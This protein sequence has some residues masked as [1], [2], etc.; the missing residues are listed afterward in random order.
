M[1]KAAMDVGMKPRFCMLKRK[2]IVNTTNRDAHV[3]LDKSSQQ[4]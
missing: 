4:T 3:M 1:K 2:G